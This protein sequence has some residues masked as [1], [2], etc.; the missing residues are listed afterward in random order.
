MLLKVRSKKTGREVEFEYDFG[1]NVS[2]AVEKYGE[3]KVYQYYVSG[4]KISAMAAARNVLDVPE[5]TEEA[6]VSAGV[7][8]VPGERTGRSRG[9]VSRSKAFKTVKA[10][11]EKGVISLDDLRQMLAE[12]EG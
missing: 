11:I 12:R 10:A 4:L 2:E 8:Y 3:E 1:S 7:G 6:A 9:E 5:N